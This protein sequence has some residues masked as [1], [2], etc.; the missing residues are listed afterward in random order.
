LELKSN[1]E[2]IMMV[3]KQILS[4]SARKPEEG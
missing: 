2:K 3:Y 4:E 1:S